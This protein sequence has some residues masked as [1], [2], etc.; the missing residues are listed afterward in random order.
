[1]STSQDTAAPA[2]TEPPIT[3]ARWIINAPDDSERKERLNVTCRTLGAP[4]LGDILLAAW[5]AG[6]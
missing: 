4:A 6:A 1:M 5:G 2:A 3:W